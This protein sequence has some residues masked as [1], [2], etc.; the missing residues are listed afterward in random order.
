MPVKPMSTSYRGELFQGVG[1]VASHTALLDPR[2]DLLSLSEIFEWGVD[3]TPAA[4]Q[5]AFALL[6]HFTEDEEVARSHFEPYTLRVVLS[7]PE[8]WTMRGQD[9]LEHLVAIEAQGKLAI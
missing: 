1:I 7:L 2:I 5:F 3:N 4:R 9:I 8:K 6:L